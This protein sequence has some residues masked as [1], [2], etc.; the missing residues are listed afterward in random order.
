MRYDF[1]FLHGEDDGCGGNEVVDVAG[2]EK[3]IAFYRFD[4]FDDW[5][6]FDADARQSM[7][8]ALDAWLDGVD[9]RGV[10]G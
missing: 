10:G 7:H 1:S 4:R 8:L 6:K 3:Y 5:M 9:F 2:D